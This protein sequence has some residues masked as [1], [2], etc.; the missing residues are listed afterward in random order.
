MRVIHGWGSTGSGGKLRNECRAYLRRQLAAKR[1]KAIVH[2]ED[3]SRATVSGREMMARWPDLE[4]SERSDSNNPG[5][6]FV[7]L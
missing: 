2:G 7:Q 6:T 1:I 4:T 3:Y 5:I